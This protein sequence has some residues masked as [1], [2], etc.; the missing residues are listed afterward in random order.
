MAKMKYNNIQIE[1][2][3]GSFSFSKSG[4]DFNFSQAFVVTEKSW[5]ALASKC[6]EYEEK[7][8]AKNAAFEF[9]YGDGKRFTF[10]PSENTGFHTVGKIEKIPQKSFGKKQVFMFT[11][12]GQLPAHAVYW[13]FPERPEWFD[14]GF[15][16]L[17][18]QVLHN[19]SRITTLTFNGKYRAGAFDGSINN[20]VILYDNHKGES[21]V[22]TSQK[23][24]TQE[25]AYI[26]KA[27]ANFIE[28]YFVDVSGQPTKVFDRKDEKYIFDDQEKVLNFDILY[29]EIPFDY[30][31]SFE[32]KIRLEQ[33]SFVRRI[34]IEMSDANSG[35]NPYGKKNAY[36]NI[37]PGGNSGFS[38][39]TAPAEISAIS[40]PK[41][42]E[43]RGAISVDVEK[44]NKNSRNT[45]ITLWDSGSGGTSVRRWLLNRMETD[46][47]MTVDYVDKEFVDFDEYEN[48]Y[49]FSLII[50]DLGTNEL[51]IYL[52]DFSEHII[53]N[54]IYNKIH[55]GQDFTYKIFAPGRDKTLSVQIQVVKVR[56]PPEEKLFTNM[57]PYP[58]FGSGKDGKDKGWRLVNVSHQRRATKR[59]DVDAEN[60][61]ELIDFYTE[62]RAVNFRWL[63]KS[64]IIA[65]KPKM[66]D[67][68][69]DPQREKAVQTG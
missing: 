36:S 63:E 55:N 35:A 2:L 31:S 1:K 37:G 50:T 56:R 38:G 67:S 32:G 12:V 68:S 62:S 8:N 14:D 10:D 33:I 43:V 46:F 58:I 52:A 29:R 25:T 39:K 4:Y 69:K 48:I 5:T 27:V 26:N 42:Y 44:I 57:Y 49:S 45:M 21:D 3:I 28:R 60:G 65:G 54:E 15:E 66:G 9:T 17:T 11:L 16:Q 41:K 20:S 13:D 51:L 24:P 47:G 61:G 30:D 7:L 19:T 34:D 40:M 6:Q 64:Q 59:L 53:S 23:D 18:I 22:V